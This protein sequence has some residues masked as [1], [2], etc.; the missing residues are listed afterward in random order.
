MEV[1]KNREYFFKDLE[2]KA[3]AQYYVRKPSIAN[4]RQNESEFQQAEN[5]SRNYAR[6]GQAK[7]EDPFAYH[8]KPINFDYDGRKLQI[9]ETLFKNQAKHYPDVISKYHLKTVGFY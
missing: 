5:K 8:Q 7:Y 6:S 1:L 4:T 3:A 2:R 9:Q